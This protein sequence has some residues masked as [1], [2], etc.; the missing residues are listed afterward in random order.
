MVDETKHI[1]FHGSASLQHL[2]EMSAFC[3]HSCSK[4]LTLLVSCIVNDA[5]VHAVPNVQQT[6]LQFNAV[7]RL[8]H[9]LL[10]VTLYLCHRPD[11]GRR[12]SAV[13]DLDE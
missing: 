3:L 7:Q 1:F 2:L 5:L 12:Y 8:M 4:T 11:Y 6:L 10:D 13:T 9:S